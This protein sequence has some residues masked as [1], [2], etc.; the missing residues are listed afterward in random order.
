M[1][2]EEILAL[3]NHALD[4]LTIKIQTSHL[5]FMDPSADVRQFAEMAIRGIEQ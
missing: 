1:T 4:M 3:D 5:K 2:N